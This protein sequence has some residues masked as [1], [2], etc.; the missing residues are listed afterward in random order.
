M[1]GLNLIFNNLYDIELLFENIKPGEVW[2]DRVYKLAGKIIFF[3]I[4]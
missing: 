2:A 4:T 3:F 1:E